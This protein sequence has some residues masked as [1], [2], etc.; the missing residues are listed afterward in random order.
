VHMRQD[1]RAG[2]LGFPNRRPSGVSVW[3]RTVFR[4]CANFD[5]FDA[6]ALPGCRCELRA[7]CLQRERKLTDPQRPHSR[8]NRQPL[9][10]QIAS[11]EY[12]LRLDAHVQPCHQPFDRRGHRRQHLDGQRRKLHLEPQVQVMPPGNGRS[13]SSSAD[14][15][16]QQTRTLERRPRNEW[17]HRSGR[18]IR[19]T[20]SAGGARC[21]R[22]GQERLARYER[23][24]R[25]PRR[26]LRR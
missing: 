10:P 6:H 2:A 17:L 20:S 1:H 7:A 21:V 12:H 11:L 9:Q 4:G 3:S 23:S 8:R 16:M 19:T 26:P 24:R 5:L 14:I 15:R 25:H 18:G 22:C 13:T